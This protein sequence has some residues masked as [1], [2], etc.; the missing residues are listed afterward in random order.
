M[1]DFYITCKQ[2]RI[3]IPDIKIDKKEL[4]QLEL[5]LPS[6]LDQFKHKR[7]MVFDKNVG[8]E[9]KKGET[10]FKGTKAVMK[11]TSKSLKYTSNQVKQGQSTQNMFKRTSPPP[12][13][14]KG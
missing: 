11:E 12:M 10:G 7:G 5:N 14:Q 2:F 9:E 1:S 13:F 6:V 8:E 4:K 3:E